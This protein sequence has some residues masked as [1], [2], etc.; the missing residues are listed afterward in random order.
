MKDYLRT[1]YPEYLH[2]G[3]ETFGLNLPIPVNVMLDY[4]TFKTKKRGGGYNSFSFVST[5]RSVLVWVHK[6]SGVLLPPATKDKLGMISY[7]LICY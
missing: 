4:L 6:Q 5:G 7:L 3:E 2:T 1:A